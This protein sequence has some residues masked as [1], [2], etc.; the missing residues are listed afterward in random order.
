MDGVIFQDSPIFE[1]LP[2]GSYLV[3]VIDENDC[4]TTANAIVEVVEMNP[5]LVVSFSTIDASCHNAQNGYISIN[6]S[7]GLPPYEYSLDGENFQTENE[8]NGLGAG[9]YNIIIEDAQG[10]SLT[11]PDFEILNPDAISIDLIVDENNIEVDASGGTGTLLYTIN[12][13]NNYQESPIFPNL[14]S[15]EYTIGVIDDN[16][17]FAMQ[18]VTINATSTNEISISDIDVFPNPS[19]G[20]FKMTMN[21][22]TENNIH[23]S[24]VD[25]SGKYVWKQ[26]YQKSGDY[27]EQN[28]QVNGLASGIYQLVITDGEQYG[29]KRL[30]ITGL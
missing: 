16:G 11:S 23:V 18:D 20:Q 21:Q 24:L 17:C 14:S 13:G 5:L 6:V 2:N 1:G 30:S 25:M 15:G 28:I 8:F 27:F 19:N 4:T 26:T 10:V 3:I 9:I 22:A 29:V 12:G 7:G